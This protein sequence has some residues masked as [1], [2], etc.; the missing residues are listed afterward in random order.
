MYILR[1]IKNILINK[2]IVLLSS[3]LQVINFY[4]FLLLKTNL[5]TGLK[6]SVIIIIA[7]NEEDERYKKINFL[8]QKYSLK[9]I[10]I[11]VNKNKLIKLC[12]LLI[13]IRKKLFKDIKCLVIGNLFS[14]INKE[15]IKISE[16]VIILDD[17]VNIFWN[18]NKIK[19]N[20]KYIF[21]SIFCKY[22]FNKNK[23]IK[24][25]LFHLKKKM[26][27]KLRYSKK[28]FMIGPPHIY[29]KNVDKNQ[30]AILVK[31]IIL[32]FKNQ[33]IYYLPHPKENINLI[34]QFK[35]LV[36]IKTDLPVEHY[37]VRETEIPKLIISFSS[38][39]LMSLNNISNKFKFFNIRPKF[40]K[41]F[42]NKKFE[43]WQTNYIKELYKKNIHTYLIRV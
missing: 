18:E 13:K 3:Q 22:L 42:S 15:F 27:R 23:Y 10:V 4:E 24:N 9:N 6:D 28:L 40:K 21:F 39:S 31:K 43:N 38:S 35:E 8:I 2:N 33:K 41:F 34:K 37:F 16:K 19:N 14:M 25:N 32:K 11:K 20:K 1:L 29:T 12:Y 7:D 36:F 5:S 17:G 26:N 30:Y